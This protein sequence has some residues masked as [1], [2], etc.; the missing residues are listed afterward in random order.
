MLRTFRYIGFCWEREDQSL[1]R[2]LRI[3]KNILQVRG[4]FLKTRREHLQ[5]ML[6]TK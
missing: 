6:I 3:R 1:M 5:F 2:E 4:C